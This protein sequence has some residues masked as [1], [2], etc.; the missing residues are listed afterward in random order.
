MWSLTQL[1]CGRSGRTGLGGTNPYLSPR[2]P[3]IIWLRETSERHSSVARSDSSS[4]T[5][6]RS[7]TSCMWRQC[8]AARRRSSGNTLC[9]K[10]S[11]SACMSLNVEEI[12]TRTLRHLKSEGWDCG[13]RLW[14]RK[15]DAWNKYIFTLTVALLVFVQ[16]YLWSQGPWLH[17]A[18]GYCIT[19]LYAPH[20]QVVWMILALPQT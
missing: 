2:I 10:M 17:L 5:P 19:C 16:L 15:G 13:K 3:T 7:S 18:V 1:Y 9:T 14:K 6:Q 11:R 4:V 12:N 8:A 20:D